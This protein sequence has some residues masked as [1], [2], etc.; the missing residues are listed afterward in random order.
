VKELEV[1]NL[2]IFDVMAGGSGHPPVRQAGACSVSRS[3]FQHIT[4]QFKA[5]VNDKEL[6]FAF[7][8]IKEGASNYAAHHSR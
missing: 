7:K 5:S 4:L 3:Q 8:G 6:N 2:Y 1:V